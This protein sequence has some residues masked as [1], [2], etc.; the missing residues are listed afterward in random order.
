VTKR[1]TNN[2]GTTAL[3]LC[4]LWLPTIAGAQG[5]DVPV[6]I[7]HA[8]PYDAIIAK[9]LSVGG[10]VRF[11]YENIDAIAATIPVLELEAFESVPGVQVIVKDQ[12]ITLDGARSELEND[13]LGVP[14]DT[15]TVDAAELSGDLAA[16][17]DVAPEGYYPTEVDLMRASDFWGATGHAGEGVIV[18]IMDSGTADVAAISGRVIGGENFVGDGIPATSPSNGPHGTWVATTLGANVIFGFFSTSSL[19]Q[20]LNAYL[21]GTVFPDY[22]GPGIAGVS[23]VGPAPFAEFYALKIFNVNGFTSNSII[24]AAFDRAIELQ[25]ALRRRRPVRR[26]PAGAERLLQR[27]HSLR[28]QRPLLR[29]H[30]PGRERRRDRDLLL[31]QQ[32]RTGH[33]DRRRPRHGAEHPDRRLHERRGLRESA[34]R[35]AVRAGL[36]CPLA[37]QRRSPGLRVQLARADGRWD[38][39]IV[40][41]GSNIFAQ[42]ASGGLSIVSGTSFSAPNVAGAAVLLISA[43][44]SLTPDEVRGKLLNGANPGFLDD[45][46]TTEDQGFG[47]VDMIGALNAPTTNPADVGS[48]LEEVA[49]NIEALGLTITDEDHFTH[50][51]DWMVPGEGHEVF[52]EVAQPHKGLDISVAFE[53]ENPPSGQNPLFGDSGLFSV[54]NSWTHVGTYNTVQLVP[55]ST[56]I[57]IPESALDFGLVR[58]NLAGDDDN[59]GRVR[60]TLTVD[61]DK[62]HPVARTK[63]LAKGKVGQSEVD[64]LTFDVETGLS[65]LTLYLSWG[66]SWAKWPTND[67]DLIL[68]DPDGFFNFA[69]AT[70]AT[71]E[72]VFLTNPTAGTWT[73]FVQGF[74]VWPNE[75]GDVTEP[76]K[77]TAH[78]E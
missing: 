28:R 48:E 6:L 29:R 58:I 22:F 66:N 59:A 64:V 52:I 17:S 63:R 25:A 18:G 10:V 21:P 40:A 8:K 41:P 19:V 42:A 43:T 12:V 16:F 74:T 3:A 55:G 23:M 47:F 5:G 32:R 49:L 78:A 54:T 71:P 24:L 9:V 50:T 20:A 34:P 26:Q 1:I 60:A 57:S 44:P 76:Y 61:K 13:A 14:E 33:D 7:A 70:L 38:P 37:R 65:E 11:E 72:R 35:P 68:V 62:G 53:Q 56:S 51:T 69:G 30:D 36:R 77:L 4:A 75:D 15:Y 27:G 45:N 39:D 73:A 67:L 46:P 2:L 31:G